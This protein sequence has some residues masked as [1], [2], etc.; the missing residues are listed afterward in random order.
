MLDLLDL[1]PPEPLQRI[2]EEVEQLEPG[3]ILVARTPRNPRMLLP[4][5]VDRGVEHAVV[6]A[7]DGTALL[8]VERPA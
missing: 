3:D 8:R 5:L 7:P 6:E 1:E 4:R 2:L